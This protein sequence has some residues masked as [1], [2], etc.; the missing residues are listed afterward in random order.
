M[1]GQGERKNYF[2]SSGMLDTEKSWGKKRG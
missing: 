2:W 1:G